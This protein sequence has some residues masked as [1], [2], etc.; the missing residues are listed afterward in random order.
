VVERAGVAEPAH[1]E[2][3]VPLEGPQVIAMGVVQVRLQ[4]VAEH[5]DRPFVQ[6]DR[7]PGRL[8]GPSDQAHRLQPQRPVPPA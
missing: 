1:G 6:R 8:A 3:G 7:G 4:D 5:L 2:A